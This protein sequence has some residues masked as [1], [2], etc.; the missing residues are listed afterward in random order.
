MPNEDKNPIDRIRFIYKK[1]R[2]HRTF[3][4]DGLWAGIT[5]QLEV[6]IAFFNNLRP[7]PQDVTHAVVKGELVGE[8]METPG[9]QHVIRE[10]D[11]TVVLNREAVRGAIG[12]LERMLKQIDQSIERDTALRNTND[13]QPKVV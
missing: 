9:E 7:M 3:H 11:A 10:V 1:T 6:Q 13:S 4:A 8:G 5:P 2:H 12:L